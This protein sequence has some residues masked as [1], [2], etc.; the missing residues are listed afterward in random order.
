M[1]MELLYTGI[2]RAQNHLTI[3]VQDDITTFIELSKIEKSNIRK[4]NSSIFEFKPLPDLLFALSS[5]WYDDNKIIS[6]L[7]EYFV[8]SKS[9][10]NIANILQLKEIPFRYEVPKFA[11]DGS[12][13]LPD[14]T[15]NWQGT[16]YFW[17]HVG[18]LDLPEYKQHWETKKKWY[19]KHFPGQLIETFEGAD[20][21]KQI[22]QILKDK[23]NLEIN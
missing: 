17:E 8:R 21:T 7:S 19:E 5:N 20:Q 11:S 12:M 9:E 1:S 15:I 6:T 14:F 10:M 18:R 16:E 22:Q 13:Y 23:F 4:I 2:T 3:F